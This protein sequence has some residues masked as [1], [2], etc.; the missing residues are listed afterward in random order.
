MLALSLFFFLNIYD[1]SAQRSKIN[2]NRDWKFIIGDHNG[3]EAVTYKD[4]SWSNVA[5]PHSFSMPYFMSTEFYTG[6]G[7]YRKTFDIHDDIKSKRFYLEFEAAF[8]DAEIFLNGKKV[9]R[10]KGGYTG[11]LIDITEAVKNDNNVLAVRLNNLWN[12][13]LAPR[14]GEHVFS[15]GIYR[16]VY[17]HVTSPVHVA[18]HGTFVTTPTANHASANIKVQ[19]EVKNDDDESKSIVLRTDILDAKGHLVC[20]ETV[21]EQIDKGQMKTI[22][23]NMNAFNNPQLWSPEKPVL[24]KAVQT[25]MDGKTKADEYETKFGIRSLKWTAD[26]GFFLNNKHY[27]LK[28]AN[29]HQDH[30]G[31]GDAVTNSGF[32]RDVKMMKEAGFNLIRGSHYP[33]DPS[34]AEA[35]DE[36]GMLFWSE[37]AFWGIGG[38]KAEG[39][40]N[41]SAYPTKIED[42]E[43]FEQSVLQQ[44]GEMIRISRNHPSIITWSMSN[45]PFFSTGAVISKM[46][47]LLKKQ[48][49]LSKKLDATRAVAIGGAQRPLDSN[50]I[51]RL[52]DIAGYNGDGASISVFQSPGVAS[53]VSEYGSVTADRPGVYSPQWGDLSKG[54]NGQTPAW[55]SGE[56]IWCGFDHGSIAGQT[57]G[58][59]G[60]VDY[61]RIPKQAYYWYRQAYAGVPAPGEHTEAAA[62]YL[63]LGADRVLVKD[64]N[65]GEDVQLVVSALSKWGKVVK[66]APRVTLTVIAGPGEF[67]TGRSIRFEQG[68]DIRIL[69]GQAAIEF[70]SYYAGKTTIV[71]T[72]PGLKPDTIKLEFEGAVRYNPAQKYTEKKYI[73]FETSGQKSEISTFGP[74]NPAFSSSSQRNSTAGFGVDA[75]LLTF[76]KA[77]DNDPTP[78]FTLDTEKRIAVKGINLTFPN[79]K[80]RNYSIE[81]SNDKINWQ[82]L[83]KQENSTDKQLNISFDGKKTGRFIKV[84]FEKATL[85]AIA[86]LEVS[87]VVLE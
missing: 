77:A 64:I 51:D 74:N 83:S 28:G 63:K 61:F 65:G 38:F 60:I 42:E 11:F 54:K 1:A 78:S 13:R 10:H 14:A 19:T 56:A 9:G 70:R 47:G 33:H 29:V 23:Q 3:A 21:K 73:R 37:N 39:Y 48:V 16:D 5:L 8:Q 80:Q 25:L 12:P 4:E 71:A 7:W 27:Y 75:N 2:F 46:R 68:S 69:D 24:Y 30:A 55:R 31:W 26:S 87:G 15:G 34:F 6:Y 67:P 76:W 43:E 17:L 40:W 20:S 57:L 35:C 66:S 50:R 45:E 81:I 82:I 84:T 32:Y 62:D 49:A 53:V 72:S 52:G 44:L 18:W 36:L 22:V 41:S 79:V 85:S 58:K 59:M 86:E